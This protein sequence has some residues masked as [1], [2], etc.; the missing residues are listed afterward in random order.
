MRHFQL[1]VVRSVAQQELTVQ[2]ML[3]A[4]YDYHYRRNISAL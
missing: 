1:A 4:A 2:L 3:A